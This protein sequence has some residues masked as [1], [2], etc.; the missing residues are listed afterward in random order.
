MIVAGGETIEIEAEPVPKVVDVTG[1]GDLYAAGFLYGLTHGAS[2]PTADAWAASPPPRPSAI[3]APG[4]RSP[5]ASWP[6]KAA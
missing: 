1:A 6:R 3:S 2:L 5:C 4:P